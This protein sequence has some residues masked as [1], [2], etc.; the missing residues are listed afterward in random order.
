MDSSDEEDVIVGPGWA[1]IKLSINQLQENLNML[2]ET[3]NLAVDIENIKQTSTRRVEIRDS[4]RRILDKQAQFMEK[5]K[6]KLESFKCTSIDGGES[7]LEYIETYITLTRQVDTSISTL[8]DGV[9]KQLSLKTDAEKK[10]S[11]EFATLEISF[12]QLESQIMKEKIRYD[13]LTAE[14]NVEKARCRKLEQQLVEKSNLV[15]Q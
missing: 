12:H 11:N 8:L 10:L 3:L 15:K 14:V 9:V 6:E 1:Q 13:K 4:S 7:E 5:F 2:C